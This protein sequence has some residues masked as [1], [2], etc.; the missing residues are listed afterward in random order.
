MTLRN[1]EIK[2][3]IDVINLMRKETGISVGQ[4]AKDIMISE[5]RLSEM[6][7]YRRFPKSEYCS[8]AYRLREY[9][10]KVKQRNPA[11]T[12]QEVTQK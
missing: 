4:L 12:P 11:K 7:N 3:M 10:K 5:S 6:L 9:I 8:T 1:S 2:T